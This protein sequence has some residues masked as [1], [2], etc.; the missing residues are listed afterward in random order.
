MIVRAVPAIV[1]RGLLRTQAAPV[2]FAVERPV[3]RFPAFEAYVRHAAQPRNSVIVQFLG[4]NR[5]R[6]EGGVLLEDG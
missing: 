5:G 1:T 4:T 6:G 2:M 3:P